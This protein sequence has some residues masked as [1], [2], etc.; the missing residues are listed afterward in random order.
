VRLPP[1]LREDQ[2]EIGAQRAGPQQS[3][4]GLGARPAKLRKTQVSR[5]DAKTAKKNL[6]VCFAFFAP[7]REML[8]PVR[9][10]LT[11]SDLA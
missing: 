1:H 7:L 10:V 8:G 6:F 2:Q 11:F 4:Q 3:A 5:E 9:F